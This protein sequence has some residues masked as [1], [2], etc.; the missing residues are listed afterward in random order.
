MDIFMENTKWTSM[1]GNAVS[2]AEHRPESYGKNLT[3]R[4]P[5]YAPLDG[6]ALRFTFDNYCGTE[7]VTITKATVAVAD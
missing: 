1:W 6:E 7:A 2:I 5:V 3:L 4:Y